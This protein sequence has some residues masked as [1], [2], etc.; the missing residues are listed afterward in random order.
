[1]E[2][3]VV[4]SQHTMKQSRIDL[5][6]MREYRQARILG[7]LAT[8]EG[9]ARSLAIENT[10]TPIPQGRGRGYM[11]RADCYFAQKAVRGLAQEPTLHVLRPATL[12]D[13]RSTWEPSKFEY[14]SEGS[15]GSGT[16]S[17]GY[18]S[19]TTVHLITTP[20]IPNAVIPRIGTGN[21]GN[22]SIMTG[23]KVAR[24][25]LK[26]RKTGEVAG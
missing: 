1:M 3:T 20:T 7:W 23:E 22:R 2:V 6:N 18:S 9:K 16:D 26:S 13:Y 4:A 21:T 24:P 19:T 12:E 17:T 11:R 10:K 25:M 8:V 5:A 14:E 15:E